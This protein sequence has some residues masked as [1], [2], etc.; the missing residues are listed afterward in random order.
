M[1]VYGAIGNRIP[2]STL[3]R[4]CLGVN[5][6][7]NQARASCILV[8]GRSA[9]NALVVRANSQGR[10]ATS[11]GILFTIALYEIGHGEG[12]IG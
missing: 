2:I 10:K 6:V 12:S 5:P 9:A 7:F 1:R 4:A 11:G 8:L 3:A